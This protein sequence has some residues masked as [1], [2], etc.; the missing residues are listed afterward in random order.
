MPPDVETAL[1]RITQEA[2]TNVLKHAEA[3][4][5]SLVLARH[6]SIVT[7]VIEDDG[8]G[9][10]SEAITSTALAWSGGLGLSGMRERLVLIGGSM[11]IESSPGAGTTIF[12]Q[13]PLEEGRVS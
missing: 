6:P 2:L 7:A 11:T 1:F 4:N 12:V 13:I 3:R 9:F 10:D 8:K 5:V